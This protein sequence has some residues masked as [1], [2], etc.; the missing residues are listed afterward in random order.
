MKVI[1]EESAVATSTGSGSEGQLPAARSMVQKILDTIERLNL[2]ST[3]GHE[4]R[5][6]GT[7]ER[8]VSG[9]PYIAV[10]ELRKKPSAVLVFTV[11]HGG[12]NRYAETR[13]DCRIIRKVTRSDKSNDRQQGCD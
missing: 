1:I 5:G 12:Q 8:G 4:G 6:K 3:M 13:Y 7:Y 9:T 11:V 2:F 10:Y